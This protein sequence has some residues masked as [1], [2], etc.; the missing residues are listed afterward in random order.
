MAYFIPKDEYEKFV[1]GKRPVHEYLTYKALK[2]ILPRYLDAF[3]RGDSWVKNFIAE[4]AHR[5]F[6]KHPLEVTVEK[7]KR[8]L[9]FDFLSQIIDGPSDVDK[10]DSLLR[11]T[12]SSGT[13]FGHFDIERLIRGA[14]ILNN[15]LVFE[16]Q[17]LSAAESLVVER[18]KVYRWI[19]FH[20]TIC[21]TDELMSRIIEMATLN[22]ILE[23]YYFEYKYFEDLADID[24]KEGDAPKIYPTIVDDQFIVNKVRGIK[25]GKE[26]HSHILQR[27]LGMLER[28]RFFKPLWKVTSHFEDAE[29][30]V[31][32]DLVNR[33]ETQMMDRVEPEKRITNQIEEDL[34]EKLGIIDRFSVLVAFKPYKPVKPEIE[35]RIQLFGVEKT[36][37]LY[38]LSATLYGIMMT[39]VGLELLRAPPLY[40]PIYVYLPSKFIPNEAE[41]K[42]AYDKTMEVISK[43][44]K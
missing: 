37:F 8:S 2:E 44:T 30:R 4:N 6:F 24:L 13:E 26:E 34:S 18:Y 14:S 39:K 23:P 32:F 36:E 11:D 1:K 15:Q 10:I 31:L 35:F 3:W 38:R 27:Y 42:K 9:P 12:R 7:Y 19:H 5:M 43:Y 29:A 28:R 21:F 33:L 41:R 16:G 17:A 40:I 22:N 25:D 20:H